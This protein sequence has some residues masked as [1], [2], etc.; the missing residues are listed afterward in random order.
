MVFTEHTPGE[1]K[2]EKEGD[3]ITGVL[4][5][6]Q[7]NVGTHKNSNLYTL[8]CKEAVES[9][10]EIMKVWGSVVLDQKMVGLNLGDRIKIVYNGIGIASGAN[11]P[12]KLFTVFVD[13]PEKKVDSSKETLPGPDGKITPPVEK[14]N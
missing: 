9:A 14:V 3:S 5:Q 4:I 12:P 8:D 7:S 6:I 13:R 10:S 1:W 11:N 2:Y